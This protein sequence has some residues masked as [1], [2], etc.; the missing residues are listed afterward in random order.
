MKELFI[1][2]F[3]TLNAS[4]E[5]RNSG[6]SERR[7]N[8]R[9]SHT[10]SH[11]ARLAGVVRRSYTQIPTFQIVFGPRKS[12]LC[13]RDFFESL[14]QPIALPL[15]TATQDEVRVIMFPFVVGE[16]IM[17]NPAR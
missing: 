6:N 5:Q 2:T 1:A 10:G 8:G 14:L 4:S 11:L 12:G 17:T 3:H 9:R 15:Q 13:L 7:H 16:Y